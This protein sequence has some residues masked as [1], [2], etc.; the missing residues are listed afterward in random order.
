MNATPPMSPE[1]NRDTWIDQ[2]LA[3]LRQSTERR[4]ET[5]RLKAGATEALPREHARV[6]ARSARPGR[7]PLRRVR[8]ELFARSFDIAAGVV[9]ALSAI[10]LGLLVGILLH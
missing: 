6:D 2:E 8:Q 5:V 10:A 4:S 7:G 3:S 9:A 1:V